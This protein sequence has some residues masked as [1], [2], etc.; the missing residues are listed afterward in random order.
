LNFW[1]TKVQPVFLYSSTHKYYS[2]N[3][4]I[5]DPDFCKKKMTFC[6]PSCDLFAVLFS[7]IVTTANS[8]FSANITKKPAPLHKKA[9][10]VVSV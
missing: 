2:G 3:F 6:T 5:P 8:V 9:M 4:G 7:I 1:K 10:Q